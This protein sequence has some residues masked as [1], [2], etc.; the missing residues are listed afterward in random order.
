[1]GWPPISPR[2]V[3]GGGVWKGWTCLFSYPRGK[4]G[5][6]TISFPGQIILAASRG[7]VDSQRSDCIDQTDANNLTQQGGQRL[8]PQRTEAATSY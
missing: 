5:V 2:V 4:Q 3:V 8:S 1:M 7:P 6:C